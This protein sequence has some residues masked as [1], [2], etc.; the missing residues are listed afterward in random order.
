MM[1]YATQS[2]I[3]S[4]YTTVYIKKKRFGKP[5]PE[6]QKISLHSWVHVI[7]DESEVEEKIKEAVEEDKS[8]AKGWGL[9]FEGWSEVSY[10]IPDDS[11]NAGQRY[12]L[13]IEYVKDM[14]MEKIMKRLTGEEFKRF[15]LIG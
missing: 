11:P 6:R 15:L 10:I 1:V 3:L 14:K 5:I 13:L 9:N 2:F 4:G 7:C 8:L 12:E